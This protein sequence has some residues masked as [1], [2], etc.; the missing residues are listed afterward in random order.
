MLDDDVLYRRLASCLGAL[1]DG[2]TIA[3]NPDAPESRRRASALRADS[4]SQEPGSALAQG[5]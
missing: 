2:A 4:P 3:M 1:L 5:A